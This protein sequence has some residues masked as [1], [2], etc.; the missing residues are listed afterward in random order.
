MKKR[1]AVLALSG[2]LFLGGPL[3]GNVYA[4]DLSE[5]NIK[6]AKTQ[7][8]VDRREHQEKVKKVKKLSV[9]PVEKRVKPDLLK[10]YK[11]KISAIFVA[12][13]HVD[14]INQGYEIAQGADGLYYIKLVTEKGYK[15]R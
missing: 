13:N 9:K 12:L 10:G 4:K 7:E 11:T 2:I 1:T 15:I 6:D 5:Q 14:C 8:E 3:F